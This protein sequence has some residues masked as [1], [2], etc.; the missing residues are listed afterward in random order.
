VDICSTYVSILFGLF[1]DPCS[2]RTKDFLDTQTRIT[3]WGIPNPCGRALNRQF[4]GNKAVLFSLGEQHQLIRN[5]LR[6]NNLDIVLI[7]F[8]E[9]QLEKA[10][11]V[12][13]GELES[14]LLKK[15]SGTDIRHMIADFI[16]SQLEQVGGLKRLR[17]KFNS[18]LGAEE[19]SSNFAALIGAIADRMKDDLPWRDPSEPQM[20]NLF[21]FC[22]ALLYQC[23][24]VVHSSNLM[25]SFGESSKPMIK[26]AVGFHHTYVHMYSAVVKTGQLNVFNPI[27]C[28]CRIAHHYFKKRRKQITRN[29]KSGN[30]D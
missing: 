4:F 28:S 1:A 30:A 9:F 23:R 15:I 3:R 25:S 18:A 12:S 16:C 7:P 21:I 10:I 6:K 29:E 22:C 8:N 24:I 2:T 14:P 13:L 5:E 11:A 19:T 27:S 17:S 26:I 20:D